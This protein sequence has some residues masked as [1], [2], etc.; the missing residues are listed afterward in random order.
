MLLPFEFVNKS[1]YSNIITN[2]TTSVMLNTNLPRCMLVL[3]RR[4]Q[5]THY[6]ILLTEVNFQKLKL[7]TVI[8]NSLNFSLKCHKTFIHFNHV[9]VSSF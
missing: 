2:N 1:I 5:H 9:D 4:K 6:N 8:E 3:V 7:T